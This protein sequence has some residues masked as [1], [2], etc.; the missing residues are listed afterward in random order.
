MKKNYEEIDLSKLL[1]YILSCKK[2]TIIII[3]TSTFLAL[4]YNFSSPKFYQ[5]TA[6]VNSMSKATQIKFATT[7]TQNLKDLNFFNFRD[8]YDE[9]NN[10]YNDYYL[11]LISQKNFKEYLNTIS[12]NHKNFN[13]LYDLGNVNK[14]I[15]ENI[16]IRIVTLE[17][18]NFKENLDDL[19]NKYLK[20]TEENVK[21]KYKTNFL[22][23]YSR[24]LII[25]KYQL[26]VT[27][28]LDLIDKNAKKHEIQKLINQIEFAE[29]RIGFLNSDSFFLDSFIFQEA[30]VVIPNNMNLLFL[31]LISF[32]SSLLLSI[33]VISIRYCLI[34]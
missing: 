11:S 17:S 5:T 24:S 14:Y 13:I 27:R 6:I 16:S 8:E 3:F 26:E 19:L 31:L 23:Y 30:N 22:D 25:L 10:I 7:N 21:K 33:F 12:L 9:Y 20:Y 18:K 28:N 4:A 15:N 2:I 1:K 32:I 34:K 29:N